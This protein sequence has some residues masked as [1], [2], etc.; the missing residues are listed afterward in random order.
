MKF[1]KFD[2][3][4]VL[5]YSLEIFILQAQSCPLRIKK[6]V[7]ESSKQICKLFIVLNPI[8]LQTTSNNGNT[9]LSN[10]RAPGT[11][12]RLNKSSNRHNIHH[13]YHPFIY[14][15]PHESTRKYMAAEL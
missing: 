3:N 8:V 2:V 10:Y 11:N 5:S 13:T 1:I 9:L 6:N 15:R 4:L 7:D 14:N 12:Y